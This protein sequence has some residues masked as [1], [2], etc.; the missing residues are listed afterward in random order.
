MDNKEI[1]DIIEE[2]N[3]SL[4]EAAFGNSQLP[5]ELAEE[6][7]SILGFYFTVLMN[8]HNID[9]HDVKECITDTEYHSKISKCINLDLGIDAVYIDHNEEKI[10]L[11]NFKHSG[12][13]KQKQSIK[14]K[15][16]GDCKQF[17]DILESIAKKLKKRQ[18]IEKEIK[19][20]YTEITANKLIEIAKLLVDPKHE[21]KIYLRLVANVDNECKL[22]HD[23]ISAI[24]MIDG[25]PEQITLPRIYTET[26]RKEVLKS[27]IRIDDDDSIHYHQGN[28]IEALVYSLSLLDIVRL[29]DI[30]SDNRE[31]F[32]LDYTDDKPKFNN[33]VINDNVRGFL[34]TRKS[35]YNK[36]ILKTLE[37]QPELFFVYNN[38]ITIIVDTI[39]SDKSGMGYILTLNNYQIV[40]GGQTIQSIFQFIDNCDE[41]KTNLEKGRVLTKIIPT[42]KS[43]IKPEKIAEYTNSQ[44]PITNIDLRSIDDTQIR[45][46]DY[47]S[48]CNIGYRRKKGIYGFDYNKHS[49]N[50][51]MIKLGQ[52]LYADFGC[53][54]LAS[55][56][57]SKIFGTEYDTLFKQ[58]DILEKSRNLIQR[59][60]EIK[61]QYESSNVNGS[62]Q[63][64][65]Y[66][67]YILKNTSRKIP[68]A[69]KLLEKAIKQYDNNNIPIADS[70]KLIKQ[71][72]KVMIDNMA[73]IKID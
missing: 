29:A 5:Q 26:Y 43:E 63:K 72:F 20:E 32:K 13:Y 38:G 34:E 8:E 44:N 57:R 61:E 62:E 70:R 11:Y 65:F 7:R 64:I 37:T 27:K 45:I 1:F 31:D 17:L 2:K 46:E 9:I 14:A 47:L 56:T 19:K 18:E 10:Y 23:E 39:E 24:N 25:K 3:K 6:T 21:Y 69:I 68:S 59:Y 30:S 42:S 53:P 35:K 51:E 41:W 67:I 15:T 48:N 66:I 50:I 40:N 52:L 28:K 60:F 49:Q 55:N 4:F 73:K 16:L 12:V 58:N 33:N 36:Q 22:N 71:D 54:H